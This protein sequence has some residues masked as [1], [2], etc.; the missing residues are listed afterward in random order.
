ME[1][2]NRGVEYLY[3]PET[4]YDDTVIRGSA[5]LSASAAGPIIR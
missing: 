5:G 4:Y 2:K 3:V 1:M